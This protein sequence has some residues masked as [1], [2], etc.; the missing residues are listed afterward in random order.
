M[1]WP[2]VVLFVLASFAMLALGLCGAAGRQ[3]PPTDCEREEE[4]RKRIQA[5]D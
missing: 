2:L 1:L 5:V 4:Q 3:P